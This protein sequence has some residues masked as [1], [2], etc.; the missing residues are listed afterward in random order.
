M[1][2]LPV[3]VVSQKEVTEVFP[4]KVGGVLK[5]VD[6]DVP[7][8]RAGAL[9][10]EGDFVRAHEFVK[11]QRGVGQHEGIAFSIE[12]TDFAIDVSSKRSELSF[13]RLSSHELI[14]FNSIVYALAEKRKIRFARLS[15]QV[16][17]GPLYFLLSLEMGSA[18]NLSMVSVLTLFTEPVF[19]K[20]Q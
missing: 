3:D 11:K 7:K 5:L 12:C 20:F 18:M 13:C 10:D 1:L 19:P 15:T 4:L 6:H 2:L 8:V 14:V 9:K 17:H 16:L